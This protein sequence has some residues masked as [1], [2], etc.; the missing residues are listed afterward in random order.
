MKKIFFLLFLISCSG[1]AQSQ[2]ESLQELLNRKQYNQVV[3]YAEQLQAS[4]SSD[5][6][7]MYVIGQ[8]YEG[9]LKYRDA[10]RFYQHCLA[11]DS[12]QTELLYSNGRMA[13]NLGRIQE[14]EY[15]FLKIREKDTTD[16]YANY[17]LARFY[18]Q[19]GKDLQA[20]EYYEYLLEF[21]PNNP[22]LLRAVGD[23]YARL[24]DKNSAFIMYWLAF[25]NNKE[26]AGLAST[27]VNT[28]LPLPD[29]E[30][31]EKALMV[32]DTALFYNP[33]HIT[34]LQNKGMTFF[35][36]KMY[37]KADGIYSILLAKGDSSFNTLKYGGS[38][39]YYAGKLFD[40]IPPLEKAHFEDPSDIDV[41]LLLGS[42]YGRTY[43]RKKA[44]ELFEW[45]EEMLLAQYPGYMA[46]LSYT[47]LL[48]QFRADTYTRDGRR[49]EA[50]A[51]YYQQWLTS[52]QSGKLYQVWTQYGFVDLNKLENDD[53]RARNLFINVLIASDQKAQRDNAGLLPL[54]RRQ[55]VAFK[56][57]MFFRGIKEHPMISPDNKRSAVTEARLQELIQQLPERNQQ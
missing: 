6:Q 18:V 7:M 1:V 21:D 46:Y 9:L 17:Q 35:T 38:S 37:N 31:I 3:L 20:V 55:L 2:Q 14:A 11:L 52:K 19:S 49:N 54:I 32:C 41:C 22:I 27:V 34:I 4:D 8:A 15:Y 36:G 33:E 47:D 56:E 24:N 39:R 48:F 25:Q 13:A 12:T 23:C 40:A 28:L 43:D 51:I 57:D 44:Y 5:F 30:K 16:F 29:E 50:A 26:N 45:V 10:Y 53:I 42:S